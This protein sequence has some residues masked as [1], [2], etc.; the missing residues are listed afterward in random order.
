MERIVVSIFQ[1]VLLIGFLTAVGALFGAALVGL[2]V[3]LGVCLVAQFSL[4]DRWALRYR[5]RR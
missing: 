5:R 2:T 3:G 4:R 1:I